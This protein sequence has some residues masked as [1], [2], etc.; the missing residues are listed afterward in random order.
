MTASVPVYLNIGPYFEGT[1][2]I[3]SGLD[4]APLSAMWYL[5]D[6]PLKLVLLFT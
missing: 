3:F 5:S 2:S 6:K 4:Q 1:Y